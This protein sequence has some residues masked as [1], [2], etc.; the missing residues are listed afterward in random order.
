M[1]K[2]LEARERAKEL[3]FQGCNV[4]AIGRRLGDEGLGGLVDQFELEAIATESE[5]IRSLVLARPWN[6]FL[7]TRED[8]TPNELRFGRN[9]FQF[10]LIYKSP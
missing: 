1:S 4:P 2:R 9:R 3:A 10:E 7:R 8:Q 5:F 6:G